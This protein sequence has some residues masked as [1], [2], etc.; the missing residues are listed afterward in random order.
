L[1]DLHGGAATW[2]T[3]S[4]I[5]MHGCYVETAAGYPV[6]SNLAF[7][8]EVNSFRVDVTGLVRINYPGLGMGISFDR[9]T[10][11][12]QTRMRELL[13]AVSRPSVIM[14]ARPTLHS[15]SPIALPAAQNP[16]AVLQ[17]IQKFFEDRHVMGRDEFLRILR[18]SQP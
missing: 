18:K 17:A 7:A 5:S 8:I 13:Q 12:N 10:E 6:G 9:F 3:I 14:G 11:D 1:R 4:D 15:P 2:A 16:A